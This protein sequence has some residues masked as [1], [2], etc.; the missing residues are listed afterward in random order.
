[1]MQTTE[2]RVRVF[3]ISK[4][5]KWCLYLLLSPGTIGL[6]GWGTFQICTMG[7]HLIFG[8]LAEGM[9]VFLV[10]LIIST[11]K[12][13]VEIDA[14]EIRLVGG[15]LFKTRV[16]P[17]DEIEGFK[18]IPT[19]YV[20]TLH[21]VPKNPQLKKI[22]FELTVERKAE[23]LEWLENNLTNL[24]KQEY[25]RSLVEIF[26]NEQLGSTPEEKAANYKQARKWC[27][28]VNGLCTVVILWAWVFPRPY[29][30][31]IWT[32][33]VLPFVGM[34]VLNRFEG[35]AKFN[36]KPKSANPGVDFAFL[37]PGLILIL[38]AF[39]D[40]H[41]LEFAHFWLPFTIISGGLFL[42]SFFI[43]RDIRKTFLAVFLCCLYSALFGAGTTV[44][45]NGL[46]AD[47]RCSVY[48][49]KVLRKSISHGKVTTYHLTLS[50]WWKSK[51]NDDVM[52]SRAVYSQYAEGDTAK[53]LVRTGKFGVP[54][55]FVR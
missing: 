33:I 12:R 52:V 44:D 53:I 11:V 48:H 16:L 43:V 15:Y 55:Y 1:M 10:L 41:V 36:T 2:N 39:L 37:M 22:K 54:Y 27:R 47:S 9:G 28:V 30:A 26:Q 51:E 45:L 8:I 46:L 17:L 25:Q 5:W 7:S 18:I 49:A 20:K 32:L 40:W 50:P 13:R 6:L 3:R 4:F 14:T 21:V 38:R 23:L 35:I 34:W 29:G 24:D 31:A 42:V 19:Q